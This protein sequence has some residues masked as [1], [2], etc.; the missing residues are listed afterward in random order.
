MRWSK[1]QGRKWE[2][3]LL[4][5]KDTS[6]HYQ[7]LSLSQ[8]TFTKF[9]FFII[10]LFGFLTLKFSFFYTSEL[11][12]RSDNSGRPCGSRF[13][14]YWVE[15]FQISPSCLTNVTRREISGLL[16]APP[17]W[18]NLRRGRIDSDQTSLWWNSFF[19]GGKLSTRVLQFSTVAG[20]IKTNR[21]TG[22]LNESILSSCTRVISVVVSAFTMYKIFD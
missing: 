8:V 12:S 14:G 9:F 2:L 18:Q 16:W 20:R 1:T 7:F 10:I 19:R 4:E 13:G 21:E 11:K 17:C 3:L 5:F 15:V 6:A 22:K